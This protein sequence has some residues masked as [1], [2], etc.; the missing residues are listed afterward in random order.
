M[1]LKE[2]D[3]MSSFGNGQWY[4][5]RCYCIIQPFD[6]HKYYYFISKFDIHKYYYFISKFHLYYFYLFN[7]IFY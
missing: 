5:E 7:I 4:F 2:I 6:I 3:S 1:C